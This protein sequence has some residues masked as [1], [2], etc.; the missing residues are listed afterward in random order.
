LAAARRSTSSLSWRR[1][2]HRCSRS[3]MTIEEVR[4]ETDPSTTPQ[5]VL[6]F[7]VWG[8]GSIRTS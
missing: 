2:G 7:D 1:F 4:N 8:E 6:R 5:A 3:E